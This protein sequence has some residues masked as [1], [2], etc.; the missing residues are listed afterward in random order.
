M[1]PRNKY[2][3]GP[4]YLWHMNGYDKLKPYGICIHGW[5]DGF[6][7]TLLWPEA[8]STKNDPFV[9]ARYFG[10]TVCEL[11]G[12]PLENREDFGTENGIVQQMQIFITGPWE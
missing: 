11:G 12:C 5:I 9:I 7:I 2:N 1:K 4:N 10:D 6:S 3:Q 8:Y